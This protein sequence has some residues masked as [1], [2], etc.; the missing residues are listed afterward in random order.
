MGITIPV[1]PAHQGYI[2]GF[3]RFHFCL[4]QISHCKSLS[5]YAD[6]ANIVVVNWPGSPTFTDHH[7]NFS[8]AST[9][10]PA[11]RVYL[12]TQNIDARIFDKA[13]PNNN[14]YIN[15]EYYISLF[16]KTDTSVTVNVRG[17]F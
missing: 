12:C 6:W 7:Y 14:S 10:V 15:L 9:I 5:F 11:D 13:Y 16:N 8:F 4:Q 3:Y 17:Y 2:G 1:F